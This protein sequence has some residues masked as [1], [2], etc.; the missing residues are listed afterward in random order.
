MRNLFVAIM[1]GMVVFGCSENQ[2][3]KPTESDV[4]R[5]RESYDSLATKMIKSLAYIKEPLSKLT[6]EQKASV[7]AL[8]LITRVAAQQQ[9]VAGITTTD[10]LSEMWEEM[11]DI[12]PPLPENTLKRFGDCRDYELAYGVAMARCLEEGKSEAECEKESYGDLTAA[13]MCR[14]KEME[15]LPR[16]I[17]RIPGRGWP[18]HPFPWLVIERMP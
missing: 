14:M 13:V 18:T 3:S 9:V 16:I 10:L 6:D 11:P 8:L 17:D 1:V 5:V 12:C 7:A 15:E 2:S 4:A